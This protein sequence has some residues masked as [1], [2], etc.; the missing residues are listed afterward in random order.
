MP[1]AVRFGLCCAAAL[2]VFAVW[3]LAPGSAQVGI[4]FFYA[5]PVG[6][7]TWW[8]DW[9]VGLGFAVGS[10]GLYLIG[11]SV[12][13]VPHFGAALAV[14]AAVLLGIVP[15]IAALRRRIFLLEHSAEELEAIRMALAPPSMPVLPGVDAAAAFIPSELGVSG[16]F[17][18]LTNGPDGSAIAVVGDVAGHGPRAAQLATFIRA[19]LGTFIA[20]SSDPAEILT[21]A[22]AALLE[23]PG[24]HDEMV[25]AICLRFHPGSNSLSWA[26]AGHPPPLRLPELGSLGADG[27]TFLLGVREDLALESAEAS[28]DPE[29]GVI[30]YTDGATDLR[31]R[32]GTLLG[33]DGLRGLVRPHAHLPA[34]RL[35]AEIEAKLLAWAHK[36]IRDDICV[37]VLRPS[38]E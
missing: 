36:A 1:G 24:R 11:T 25:S 30:V 22:N 29:A 12:H 23:R 2:A 7:A 37:L 15:A 32:E 20:N 33:L 21:L 14:R 5:L 34:A 18:L 8:F 10:I 16:D 28:L 31:V 27:S 13:P 19:R 26:V 6:L 3:M 4:A 17:Y 38:A 9:R 35:V